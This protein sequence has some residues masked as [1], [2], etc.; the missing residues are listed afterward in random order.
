V[1]EALKPGEHGAHAAH[2]GVIR[3]RNDWE[4]INQIMIIGREEPSPAVVERIARAFAAHDDAPFESLNG[5]RYPQAQRG[6][7]KRD[8]SG[9]AIRVNFHPNPWADRVLKAIRDA[10][11]VQAVERIRPIFKDKPVEIILLSPVAVDLTVDQVVPWM[12]WRKGGT[13]IERAL[14]QSRV[15]PLSSR[16]AARL[17]PDIWGGEK[18][19]R[20]D[21]SAAGLLRQ[22]LNRE[23]Y[24]QFDAIRIG[25]VASYR[26]EAEPRKRAHEHIAL[27]AA[28]TDEARAVLEAVTGP[29][30]H[31]EIIEVIEAD[32]AAVD[33]AEA[34]EERIAIIMHDGGLTEAEAIRV[35]DGLDVHDPPPVKPPVPDQEPDRVVAREVG[36]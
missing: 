33:A 2:F 9:H 23:S 21:L 20:D 10:E 1:I 17:L 8:G 19:A 27:I 13:R 31:F 25:V 3:G 26:G 29:L 11:I 7:R 18:T 28:S 35:A 36:T 15:I 30:R 24:L 12:D 14:E 32:P 4:G 34:R 5:K 6:I 22:N 16:E